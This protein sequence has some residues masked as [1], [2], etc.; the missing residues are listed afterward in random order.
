MPKIRRPENDAEGDGT[1]PNGMPMN[2]RLYKLLGDHGPQI[3]AVAGLLAIAGSGWLGLTW[4]FAEPDL[5]VEVSSSEVRLPSALH[6]QLIEALEPYSSESVPDSIVDVLRET[7]AFLREIR[8][9]TQVSLRN[10][11]DESLGNVEIRVQN[12]G[13]LSG[14][15]VAG[16]ALTDLERQGVLESVYHDA[17]SELL[18]VQGLDRL[19]PNSTIEVLLWAEAPFL[20]FSDGRSIS[21]TFDGGVGELVRTEE[22]SGLNAFVYT[23]SALLLLIGGLVILIILT[24]RLRSD[25]ASDG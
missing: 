18:L 16:N 10:N 25:R 2:K 9:F 7:A 5:S 20:G 1:N 8:Q 4:L 19:P 15:G 11:T 13:G 12:V 17:I 14:W 6:R 22:V 24:G 21:V 3:G 23:N